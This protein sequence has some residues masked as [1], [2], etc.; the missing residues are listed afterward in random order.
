MLVRFS[1]AKK[2]PDVIVTIIIKIIYEKNCKSL[3]NIRFFS[4]VKKKKK[5]GN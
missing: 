1:D 2:N 3:L 5:L 4:F